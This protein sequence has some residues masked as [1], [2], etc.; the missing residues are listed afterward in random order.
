MT[1]RTRSGGDGRTTRESDS[2]WDLDEPA[3]GIAP[4]PSRA[5][6]APDR[7]SRRGRTGGR[8]AGIGWLLLALV[9]WPFTAFARA[10]RRSPR[11]RVWMTRLAILG[12]VLVVLACSVGVILINNVVVGRTAELG[13]LEDARRELRRDNA[14]LGAQAA[15]LTAPGI[16]YGRATR[17]LGM[18]R[19]DRVP[20]FVYLYDASR[21]LDARRRQR[22]AAAL[23]REREQAGAA[24]PANRSASTAEPGADAGGD[25]AP[26]E[27]TP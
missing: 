15:R 5:P 22:I 17:D 11:L 2:W 4:A 3:S 12:A 14:V 18:V 6:V 9:T 20:E 23:E 7:R 16:V 21:P 1:A 10:V 13:K 24:A 8:R 25:P 19:T 26:T 27:G